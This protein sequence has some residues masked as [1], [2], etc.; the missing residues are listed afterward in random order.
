[1]YKGKTLIAPLG[2]EYTFFIISPHGLEKVLTYTD[3]EALSNTLMSMK[4][5]KLTR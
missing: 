5:S 4:E 1:M 3:I 2:P